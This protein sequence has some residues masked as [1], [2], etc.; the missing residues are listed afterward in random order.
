MKYDVCI[1]GSGAGGAPIAYEL[2]RAGYKVV[3]LEK[4]SNL[5]EEDFS[6]DEIA[7]SRRDIYT[8]LLKDERHVINDREQ[9]GSITRYDGEE[10]NWSF[11]NGSMVG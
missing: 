8:P 1:I 5:T 2:S 9:D 4:G 3:V 10:Y 7:V 6:K 11:W